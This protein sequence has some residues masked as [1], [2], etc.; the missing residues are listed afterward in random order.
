[1]FT[2]KVAI[3]MVCGHACVW[4][5]LLVCVSACLLLVVVCCHFSVSV[6]GVD[7]SEQ[8]R[9]TDRLNTLQMCCL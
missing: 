8:T 3:K 5:M 1:M 4:Q 2:C 9:G 7:P 6:Y